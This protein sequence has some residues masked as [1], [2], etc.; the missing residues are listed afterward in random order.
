MTAML[1]STL[2]FSYTLSYL[3]GNKNVLADYG[4]RNIPET[5]WPAPEEDPLEIDP[6]PNHPTCS[7]TSASV[8]FPVIA[9]HMYKSEDIQGNE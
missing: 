2:E 1:V 7:I 3:P 4:T 6:F 9:K 8:A 5:D